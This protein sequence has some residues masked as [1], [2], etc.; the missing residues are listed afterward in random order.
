MYPLRHAI[1]KFMLFVAVLSLCL[2]VAC[3]CAT[4]KSRRFTCAVHLP[5]LRTGMDEKEVQ[6]T[7]HAPGLPVLRATVGASR[8]VCR[9]FD[10]PHTC[11]R[12]YAL[13]EDQR[14][15][16]VCSSEACPDPIGASALADS[17]DLIPHESGVEYWIGAIRAGGADFEQAAYGGSKCYHNEE[18]F[19]TPGEWL[20]WSPLLVV[21]LPFLPLSLASE[22][23]HDTKNAKTYTRIFETKPGEPAAALSKRLGD[24]DQI[25]GEPGV[26]EV[27]V[28]NSERLKIEDKRLV[29]S[30]G[31]R[32]SRVEWVRFGYDAYNDYLRNRIVLTAEDTE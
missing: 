3:G 5:A 29:F 19:G 25:L 9:V 32:A 11:M 28:Y 26:Y 13:W 31:L 27:W 2:A 20:M 30:L 18:D 7:L 10:T 12:Y 14:L 17:S 22:A 21:Y 4:Q 23:G 15:V 1:S 6:H 24:P 16:A 8:A